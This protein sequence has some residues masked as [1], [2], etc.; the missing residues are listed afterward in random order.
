MEAILKKTY[1]I[2]HELTV[3]IE[4][5]RVLKNVV[6]RAFVLQDEFNEISSQK[7]TNVRFFLSHN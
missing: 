3:E 5:K 1:R 6:K 7:S 4:I 2:C